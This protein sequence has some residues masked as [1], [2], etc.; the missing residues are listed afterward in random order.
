MSE[1]ADTQRSDK[2]LKKYFHRGGKSVSSNYSLEWVN[3]TQ[4]LV[5]KNAKMIIPDALKDKII[6]WYHHY[7]QHP[8]QD[9]LEA[10]INATM[11]W[12]GL[13][14]SVRRYTK[15]CPKCQKNKHTEK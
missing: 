14:V 8:G 7:L 6:D 12:K 3:N 11:T 10:T 2:V 5:N 15:K 13:K 1:I 4:V 9:R